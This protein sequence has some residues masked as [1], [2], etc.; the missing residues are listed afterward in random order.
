MPL[1]RRH[2][3]VFVLATAVLPLVLASGQAFHTPAELSD[4]PP[5]KIS[6][7]EACALQEMAAH[8]AYID[9]F[10]SS[11]FDST[12]ANLAAQSRSSIANAELLTCQASH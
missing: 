10:T 2:P 5:K 3:L 4:T 11:P 12:G 8:S 1:S 6:A 9:V 7:A